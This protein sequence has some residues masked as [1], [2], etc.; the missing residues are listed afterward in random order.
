MSVGGGVLVEMGVLYIALANLRISWVLVT[1]PQDGKRIRSS[2]RMSAF[3]G[4]ADLKYSPAMIRFRRGNEYLWGWSEMTP[5]DILEL[6]LRVREVMDELA[7][8]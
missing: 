7:P 5:D 2:V 1:R 3:E 6:A 8:K 4:K